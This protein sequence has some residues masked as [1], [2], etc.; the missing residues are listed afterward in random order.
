MSSP[1]DSS[2]TFDP[3]LPHWL[4]LA[5]G[6]LL[7]WGVLRGYSRATRPLTPFKRL[8]LGALRLFAFLM[9]LGCLLR[10]VQISHRTLREKGPCFI[11]L[12]SSASMNLRDM[13]DAHTRWESATEI[14]R[15]HQLEIERLASES[16]LQRYL[17]DGSVREVSHLPGESAAPATA[18][19]GS[20]TDLAVLL[21]KLYSEGSGA[22]SGGA[23]LMSD[24][25]HNTQGDVISAALD[26]GQAGVRVYAIGLGQES[27]P[28]DFKDIRIRE[29][30]VPE[31]AFVGAHMLLRLELESTLPKAASAPL[32]VE[33][34]GKKIYDAPVD[35]PA[36]DN[37]PAPVLEIPYVPEALGVYRVT[38]TLGTLPG[39]ADINNN[40]RSAFFRVYKS[41]LGIWYVEGAIRK[42]FG[43]LRSALESAPNVRLHAVNA[44]EKQLLPESPE[45]WDQLKL[46][47]LG[48]LSA[49]RFDPAGLNKLA[50]FVED[51]GAVLMIGGLSNFGAGGW[52]NSALAPVFP[53]ELGAGDGMKEGL[54]PISVPD[55]SATHSVVLLG[56]NAEDSAELWKALPPMPGVNRV[57]RVKP[58]AQVLLRAGARELLVVQ[59]YGKG[60]SAVFTGDMTWQWIL[61][62]QGETQKAFW[63]N[64]TTWLTRSDYRDTDKAVFADSARLQ[65]QTGEEMVLRALVH[66]TSNKESVEKLK[67]ARVLLSLGRL[68]GE[69]KPLAS[70][71]NEEMGRGTGEFTRNFAVG[72]PGAYRFKATVVNTSGVFIDSDTLDLQVTAPDLEN[73]NP[74]ANL[75][76]LRRIA[77]LSGGMYFDPEQ[78][79]DAFRALLHKQNEF[80]RDVTDVSELWNQPWMLL[81]LVGLLSLEW[82]LRKRW[83]LV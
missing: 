39:E 65:Y 59:E 67:D 48:D 41:R 75:S 43:A 23:L 8:A 50:R 21:E 36:G 22:A 24:G 7:L 72:E 82:M 37:V 38:A 60:R 9:L 27:T 33:I 12:D 77:T 35:F 26:L 11:A 64:L 58:A 62:G 56:K 53:V 25:R 74:Q 5:L 45:D 32:R 40:V 79:G 49:A 10:P 30:S 44:F 19:L 16:V 71:L 47:I 4:L 70:V 18:P 80:T 63:R 52:Q 1:A 34:N 15:K 83:G 3:V 20:S 78:A 29:L 46:V 17:F 51:G 54:L 57:G 69:G 42:E 13:P 14:L 81:T 61:K 2:F 28:A 76:L 68:Q 31:R 66:E 73:D 55:E 6:I